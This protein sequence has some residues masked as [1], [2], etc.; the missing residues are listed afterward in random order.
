MAYG[1]L[2]ASHRKLDES[3][4]RPWRPFHTHDELQKLQPG[5]IVPLEIE[6]WPTS[7]VVEHGER[8]VLE[9]GAKDDPQSFFQ[10]DDP[11]DRAR[12]G[13]NTIHTGG[14]FD[15]HLLLPIIPG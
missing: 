14:A 10:H 1:W 5:E 6:V 13:T 4:S 7:V 3:R 9:V 8:L 12:T 2:R 11:R 15:S